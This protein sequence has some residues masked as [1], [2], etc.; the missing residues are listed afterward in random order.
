MVVAPR[1][2]LAVSSRGRA[3]DIAKSE[4][5]HSVGHK[6]RS[7]CSNGNDAELNALHEAD[8]S[9]PVL[10]LEYSPYMN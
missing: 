8:A 9:S 5:E 1:L 7:M 10:T 4:A 3:E 6:A 2:F